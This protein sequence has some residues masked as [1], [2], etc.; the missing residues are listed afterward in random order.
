LQTEI[1]AQVIEDSI[2]DEGIRLTTLQLRFPRFILAEFNT[3]RQFSRNARST[4]AVPTK[5]LIQEVLDNPVV[6]LKWQKNKPGMQSSEPMTDEDAA[7]ALN[8]WLAASKSA[9][10]Y[11]AKL[12]ELGLHKQWAGRIIEPFMYVDALLSSTHWANFDGLRDHEDAQPEIELLAKKIIEARADSTP[13]LLKPG[14][15][16]LPYVSQEERDEWETL[17]EA[18]LGP[19][20]SVP[21]GVSR[22]IKLSV[23]RSARVSYT[24][25]DGNA[26]HEKEFQRYHDLVGSTPVHASPAE[27]QATPDKRIVVGGNVHFGRKSWESPEKH[28]NFLG[29]IQHRKMISGNYIPDSWENIS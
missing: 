2:S 16:H 11:A 22:L 8:L 23:A 29:W 24:P 3:H 15:W 28:G 20:A 12:F 1:S 5:K 14:E 7:E 4:R 10:L 25:F 26:S 21:K 18:P 17:V 6:P 9:A 19:Q 27:H 13:K